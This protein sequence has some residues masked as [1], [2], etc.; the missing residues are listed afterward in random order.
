Q[1]AQNN[2]FGHGTTLQL[3]AQISS[4]RQLF[5]LRYLDP[6]FLDTRLTF[7]FGAYNSLLFYPSFNKTQRGGDLTWGYLFGDFVRVYGTYKLEN[8]TVKQNQAGLVLGGFAPTAQVSPG[9]ISNLFRSGWTSSISL[10][11][12]YDSRDDRMFPKRGMFHQ[13]SVEWADPLIASE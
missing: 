2:L 9:T 1:I 13:L 10:R 3:Q 7:A 4:L 12:N 11:V 5:Q 8:V 6:Y